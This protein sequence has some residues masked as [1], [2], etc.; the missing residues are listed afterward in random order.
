MANRIVSAAL[1]IIDPGKVRW[2]WDS[3]MTS[4]P[5]LGVR[6]IHIAEGQ[7]PEQADILEEALGWM[8]DRA[9]GDFRLVQDIGK[10]GLSA[11]AKAYLMRELEEE[12]RPAGPGGDEAVGREGNADDSN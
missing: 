1:E 3:M 4:D 10:S 5:N 12:P 8:L 7:R 6:A 9:W 2:L 11:E